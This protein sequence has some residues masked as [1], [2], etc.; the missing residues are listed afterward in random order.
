M[1]IHKKAIADWELIHT[2]L[3]DQKIRDNESK[4]RSRT[5]YE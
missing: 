2:R 4:N 5:T 3:R 1:V